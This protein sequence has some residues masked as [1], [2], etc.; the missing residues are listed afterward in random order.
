[1]DKNRLI[2]NAEKAR[3]RSETKWSKNFWHNVWLK[4]TKKYGK[5][6]YH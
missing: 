3:D 6:T 4:L 2:K 5:V 1:M